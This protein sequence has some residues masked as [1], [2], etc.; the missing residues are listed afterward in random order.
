MSY[1]LS[2]YLP[3]GSFKGIQGVVTAEVGRNRE[4]KRGDTPYEPRGVGER[5]SVLPCGLVKAETPG[6]PQ[7]G[8]LTRG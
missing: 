5:R 2:D 4:K 3:S 6:G 7:R 1:Y 8:R